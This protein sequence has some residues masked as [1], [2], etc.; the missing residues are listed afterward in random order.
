MDQR[1]KGAQALSTAVQLQASG[2]PQEALA[3]FSKAAQLFRELADIAGY[4]RAVNGLGACYKD[5]EDLPRARQ[6]LEQAL[7]FRRKAADTRG[8]AIT[9]LTLGPV[10]MRLGIS[11]EASR[12][13][14]TARGIVSR[15]NDR[16]L[17]GQ[18]MFNLAQ[19][20]EAQGHT[21]EAFQHMLL[22]GRLATDFVERFKCENEAA[23]LCIVLGR[24]GEAERRFETL[25]GA[26]RQLGN[27]ALES[28]C[29]HELGIIHRIQKRDSEAEAEFR[30]SIEID[31]ANG[32]PS[33][34]VQSHLA[35]VNLYAAR[36]LIDKARR[37]LGWAAELVPGD[38]HSDRDFLVAES[39]IQTASGNQVEVRALHSCLLNMARTARNRGAEIQAQYNLS[40]AEHTLGDEAASI[41][42]LNAAIDLIESTRASLGGDT[43]RTYFG[44]SD[45]QTI[46]YTHVGRLF[47]TAHLREAFH[48]SESRRARRLMELL[49]RSKG[50]SGL[51]LIDSPA[52]PFHVEEIAPIQQ[53][54]KQFDAVMFAYSVHF[55]Y[56]IGWALDEDNFQAFDVPDGQSLRRDTEQLREA[57]LASDQRRFVQVAH[58]L[59]GA[60]ITPALGLL[61]T[62]RH[63]VIVPDDVL[64]S[65]PFHLLVS[66]PGSTANSWDVPFLADGHAI[67]YAQSATVFS[68][69]NSQPSNSL[70]LGPT[71]LAVAPGEYDEPRLTPLPGTV[72]EV[73]EIQGRFPPGAATVLLGEDAHRQAVLDGLTRKPTFA[74]IATHATSSGDDAEIFLSGRG[75]DARLNA[76]DIEA[77]H[78]PARL[79][80][81]SAC[82]TAT[83]GLDR[84]EGLMSLA[85]AFLCAGAQSVCGSYWPVDDDATAYLMS[86]LYTAMLGGASRSESL[87]RAQAA[88]REKWQHPK[89]WG[90]F[91]LYGA[92]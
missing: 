77:L 8:E 1:H 67:T 30:R 6:Y 36:G 54:L 55:G 58:R 49:F 21:A 52:A 45:I 88:T 80:V 81:L 39:A 22:A 60:L 2:R 78:C 65:L 11:E 47:H 90:G 75:E 64:C 32:T 3:Q 34:S 87:W 42:A 50:M 61:S 17:L 13:L 5:M 73:R 16:P 76:A 38:G 89:N 91:A 24:I 56:S 4:G 33:R 26:A 31:H 43:K 20:A 51:A 15:L 40:V 53:R 59:F 29:Y 18:V 46:Y 71:L 35:L 27:P 92:V 70:P 66:A 63:I 44:A 41:K 86:S 57:L 69:L 12:V 37:E 84:A 72:R 82:D 28:F 25:L 19:V 68:V 23:K 79:V 74:H 14:E 62:G 85:R 7:V 83:G 10:Y 9:L 48:A